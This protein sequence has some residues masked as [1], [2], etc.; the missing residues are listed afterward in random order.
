[1]IIDEVFEENISNRFIEKQNIPGKIDCLVAQKR[2]ID[3]LWSVIKHK[4]R[5]IIKRNLKNADPGKNWHKD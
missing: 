3:R 2:G 5:N 4:V 1:M